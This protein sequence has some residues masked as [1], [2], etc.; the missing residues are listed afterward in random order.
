MLKS[1]CVI[2]VL[3]ALL[4]A[5]SKAQILEVGYSPVSIIGW[6]NL[7]KTSKL[8]ISA[9]LKS[10]TAHTVQL[11]PGIRYTYVNTRSVAVDTQGASVKGD[12]HMVFLIPASF[13]ATFGRWSVLNRAGMGFSAPAFPN[14]NGLRL[15]FLLELGL[16][17]RLTDHLSLSGRYS[18]MSNASWGEI[19]PGVDNLVI[20]TGIHF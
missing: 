18:H 19:N 11:T 15:N 14:E 1:L 9:L 7:P 3:M 17:Y 5:G 8:D 10:D 2:V 4:P 6:G 12:F 13:E 16:R 20:A